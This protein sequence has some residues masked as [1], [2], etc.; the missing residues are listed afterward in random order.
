MFSI[1]R[2]TG[3]I[4]TRMPL[5]YESRTGYSVNVTAADPSNATSS[6]AESTSPMVNIDEPPVAVGRHRQSHRRGR[7]RR[8]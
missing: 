6:S 1:V 4:Q 5:D 7:L 2:S 8:D 3:Q